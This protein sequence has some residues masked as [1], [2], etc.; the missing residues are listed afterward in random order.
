MQRKLEGRT[1]EIYG[2]KRSLTIQGQM[3]PLKSV[4]E[5]ITQIESENF[6]RLTE[7]QKSRLSKRVAYLKEC[8]NYLESEPNEVFVKQEKDRLKSQLDGKNGQYNYWL[9]NIAPK[10]V[11]PK[12]LRTVF[13]REVGL[14]K[15]KKQLKMIEFILA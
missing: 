2:T 10:D 11:D 4:I 3:K 14:T 8:R 7:K 12:N 1:R 5:E 15:I 9:E 13:N 6:S